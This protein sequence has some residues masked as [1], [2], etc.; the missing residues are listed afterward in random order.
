MGFI[1]QEIQISLKTSCLRFK[2]IHLSDLTV[3]EP[4]GQGSEFGSSDI[5]S[6]LSPLQI[7]IMPQQ[8]E[9]HIV[10]DFSGK[11]CFPYQVNSEQFPE[12]VNLRTKFWPVGQV[13][14]DRNIGGKAKCHSDLQCGTINNIGGK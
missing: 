14:Q 11:T 5:S 12:Q 3:S 9:A 6:H 10:M 13:P 7:L 4:P 8:G 2:N 1:Q